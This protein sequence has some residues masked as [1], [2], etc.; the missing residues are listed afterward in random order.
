MCTHKSVRSTLQNVHKHE[1]MIHTLLH[2]I[3]NPYLQ[4]LMDDTGRAWWAGGVVIQLL[5]QAEQQTAE[6]CGR[7]VGPSSTVLDGA[8]RFWEKAQLPETLL[9]KTIRWFSRFV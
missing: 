1:Y 4:S 7:V 9:E 6:V 5:L 8:E 3:K 2:T